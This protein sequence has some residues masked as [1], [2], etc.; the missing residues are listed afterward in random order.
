ME[1][2]LLGPLLVREELDVVHH[3]HVDVPVRFSR[4]AIMS[5]SLSAVTKW[6][7]NVSQDRYE[8]RVPGLRSSTVWQNACRRWVLPT[9]TRPWRNSGLYAFPGCSL[10]P[11]VAA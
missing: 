2:L 10:A 6:F 8:I 5:P 7:T 3:E 4:K 9:P 1:E 11:M